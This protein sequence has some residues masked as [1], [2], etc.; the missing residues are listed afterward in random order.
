MKYVSNSKF[1][2]IEKDK[3]LKDVVQ[4]LEKESI[5]GIDVEADSMHHFEERMCTLQIATRE[6]SFVID[7]LSIKDVSLIKP[8][9]ANYAI[10]KIFHGADYDLRLIQKFLKVTVNNLFDTQIA[11]RFLGMN[12]TSLESVLLHIL[13]VNIDKKYQKSDWSKRPLP[14]EMIEYAA[15]DIYFLIPLW[16]ALSKK[17]EAMGRLEWAVE[18]SEKQKIFQIKPS[19]Q[20]PLFLKVKG[21]GN[22]DP[23][24]LFVLESL[25]KFRLKIAKKKDK[26]A[27]KIIDNEK[28]ILI[29]KIKPTSF[30]K[31]KLSKILSKRQM[32]MYGR[33]ISSTIS[34]TLKYIPNKLPTYP[35]KKGKLTPNEAAGKIDILKKWRDS[36]SKKMGIETGMLFSKNI[37]TAVAEKNP[38]TIK[39]LSAIKELKDWQIREFGEEIIK[40]L[41]GYLL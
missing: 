39:E 18:E 32:E 6:A 16:E 5:I 10:K 38:K 2:L 35:F 21:A 27:F 29:A 4:L 40:A 1:K 3:D 7:M 31:I 19:F 8:I 22:L 15:T 17:L 13:G 12:S 9:F 24:S 20:Y 36:K 14:L 33:D 41:Q 26:P 37:L 23:L 11:S 28:L 34:E 30:E 25:L